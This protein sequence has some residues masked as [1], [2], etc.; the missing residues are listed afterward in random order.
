MG[1]KCLS[2]VACILQIYIEKRKNYANGLPA[3]SSP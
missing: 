3:T 2:V 1:F